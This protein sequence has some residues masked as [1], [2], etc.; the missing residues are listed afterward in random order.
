MA[1]FPRPI[2]E[3]GPGLQRPPPRGIFAGMTAPMRG[4]TAGQGGATRNS[5][6]RPRSRS[7]Y[8]VALPCRFRRSGGESRHRPRRQLMRA[9][10]SLTHELESGAGWLGEV[11]FR[12][13]C[14]LDPFFPLPRS[15]LDA[16]KSKY[17]FS[18][19]KIFFPSTM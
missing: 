9:S 8:G 10:A 3:I 14:L 5:S 1:D 18:S 17:F 2:D 6:P 11:Q 7:C 13:G 15:T 4:P 12:F 16:K 19:L